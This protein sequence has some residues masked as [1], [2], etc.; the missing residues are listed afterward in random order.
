MNGA[1][2]IHRK[3]FALFVRIGS[4]TEL[5]RTIRLKK[6]GEKGLEYC[7]QREQVG[8]CRQ[9]R[10]ACPWLLGKT[11]L[12]VLASLQATTHPISIN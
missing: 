5:G 10:A 11:L 9:V 4:E 2:H 1:Y 12:K 6:S 3:F 8:V 7:H